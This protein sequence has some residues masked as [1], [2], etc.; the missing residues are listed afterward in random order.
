MLVDLT[1]PVRVAVGS[2]ETGFGG[3]VRE[4]VISAVNPQSEKD[5]VIPDCLRGGDGIGFE[6]AFLL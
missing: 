3:V 2:D 5:R 6:E 4:S 1:F